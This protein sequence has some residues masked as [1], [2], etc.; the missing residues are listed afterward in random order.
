M[1]GVRPTLANRKGRAPAKARPTLAEKRKDGAP[2]K[3]KATERGSFVASLLRMTMRGEYDGEARARSLGC[4]R[5]G[6]RK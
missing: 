1:A 6:I 5:S 2:T 3:A 4:T